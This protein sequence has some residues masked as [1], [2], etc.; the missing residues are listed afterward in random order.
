MEQELRKITKE[1]WNEKFL[2]LALWIGITLKVWGIFS[3]GLL[4]GWDTLPH[5]LALQK[6]AWEFLP[7]GAL[8]GYSLE[9][10]GGFPLFTFYGPLFYAVVGG[11]WIITAK[12]FSLEF[13]FRIS[14]LLVLFLF[15]ISLWYFTRAF[16]GKD[17]GKIS[18]LLGA[19]FFFYPVSFSPVGVG[20]G[21]TMFMGLFNGVLGLSLLLFWLG[22]LERARVHESKTIRNRYHVAAALLLAGI[23]YTH[24]LTLIAAALAGVI[25]F[26][27][28]FK[29]AEFRGKMALGVLA[30]CALALPFLAPF[31]QNLELSSSSAAGNIDVIMDSLTYIFPLDIERIALSSSL[32][33]F[34]FWS[35]IFFFFAVMGSI[36]LF[37][38]KKPF[39]PSLLLIASLVLIRN[40]LV[41]LFPA[42]GIHYYRFIPFVFALALAATSYGIIALMEGVKNLRSKSVIAVLL[43][44]MILQ[45]F[46]LFNIDQAREPASKNSLFAGAGI[47]YRW[48]LEKY[49]SAA[50]GQKLLEL[51]R[52]LSPSKRTLVEPSPYNYFAALGS[53][54]YFT[55]MIPMENGQ[56]TLYGL[57]AESSPLTPFIF[58]SIESLLQTA[59]Y[60]GDVRLSGLV[61][62]F[63]NQSAENHVKRLA[64]FGMDRFVAFRALTRER[65][66]EASSTSIEARTENFEIYRVEEAKPLVYESENLPIIYVDADGKL[67]FREIALA[68]FEDIELLNVPILE[69]KNIRE[70]IVLAAREA[71]SALIVSA[72]SL[73]NEEIK[74]LE[75]AALPVLLLNPSERIKTK[76]HPANWI[77]LEGFSKLDM[78]VSLALVR[79]KPSAWAPFQDIIKKFLAAKNPE[80]GSVAIASFANREIRFE[81]KGPI[82]IN[83]GYFPYWKISGCEGDV[84]CGVW[85]VTPDEMLV[86]AEGETTLRYEADG[87]KK[88]AIV[89]SWSA[90]LGIAAYF[91]FGLKKRKVE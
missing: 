2:F 51:L 77:I 63:F 13:L 38:D 90:F 32:F 42:L 89:I 68:V 27:F 7:N 23:I 34:E 86:F 26:I 69:A 30:A 39:V 76:P 5:F 74:N 66:N 82:V 71:V 45:P 72:G 29:N 58:S 15:S 47:P 73:G 62:T 57:Y 54:H 49:G 8:S 16:F 52:N 85:R 60:W 37:K 55:A 67:P 6:M 81:G 44:V 22:I 25:Y 1:L 61:P 87:I 36:R 78:P 80:A 83:A 28:H 70:A 11:F 19:L 50:E 43:G 84:V 88:V 17:A 3:N 10:F 40:Y 59:F 79:P 33:S 4:P 31:V 41:T 9:W 35:V 24:T 14:L 91:F 18:I 12:L 65:L 21:G 46:L 75:S 56:S 64:H 20:I 48:H 53:P